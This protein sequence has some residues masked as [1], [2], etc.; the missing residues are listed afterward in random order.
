MGILHPKQ[1]TEPPAFVDHHVYKAH[2]PEGP[3]RPE[4]NPNNM[5]V[6]EQRFSRSELRPMRGK[7]YGR[8]DRT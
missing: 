3:E 1:F 4:D 5:P 7:P 8:G 6:T 2:L